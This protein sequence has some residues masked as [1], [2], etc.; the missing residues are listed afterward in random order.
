MTRAEVTCS[1]LTARFRSRGV[2][3]EVRRPVGTTGVEKSY[4]LQVKSH[5]QNVGVERI[6]VNR[7]ENTSGPEV[8]VIEIDA[9]GEN[10][11]QY[12]TARRG[13]E[14]D[15]QAGD[16]YRYGYGQKADMLKAREKEVV[17][18]DEPQ[19]DNGF[20]AVMGAEQEEG[21]EEDWGPQDPVSVRQRRRPYGGWCECRE[22]PRRQASGW[23]GFDAEVRRVCSRPPMP[24]ARLGISCSGAASGYVAGS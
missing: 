17:K 24:W 7:P 15:I 1:H 9:S 3:F 2:T 12:E 11:V 19:R 23:Y 6:L 18:K 14:E 20:E 8:H 22:E 16:I 5:V 21:E 4:T 10:I 13:P